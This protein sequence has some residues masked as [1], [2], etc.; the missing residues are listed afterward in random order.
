[1][2]LGLVAVQVLAKSPY[3]TV[4]GNYRSEVEKKVY[5]FEVV[6]GDMIEYA[7]TL[8]GENGS[9]AFTLVPGK[10]NFYYL[11]TRENYYRVYL[12]G[13]Q[14]L[15]VDVDT[16]KGA[17]SL[18]GKNSKENVIVNEWQNMIREV[19]TM[20]MKISGVRFIYT[21]F[22]PVLN[23]T[24]TEYERFLTR[25]NTK[26]EAFNEEMKYLADSD[27]RYYSLVFLSSGRMKHPEKGDITD[28]HKKILAEQL[29]TSRMLTLPYAWDFVEKVSSVTRNHLK[30]NEE[31]LEFILKRMDD[32]KMKSSFVLKHLTRMRTPDMYRRFM[33]EYGK[34]LV[35]AEDRNVAISKGSK[36][37]SLQP[38]SD[39]IDFSYPDIEGKTHSLSDYKGNVIVVDIW[40]TWCGPCVKEIP[41]FKKLEEE[42]KGQDVVFMGISVDQYKSKWE[43]FVKK[44]NLTAVQLLGTP[45]I[46]D[47]Y[48][49]KGIPRFMLF[50]KNGKIVTT[51]APRPSSPEL[52][53][54]IEKALHN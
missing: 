5:L 41:F 43:A 6:N 19:E 49:I 24:V 46:R 40:A 11:G 12:Q 51:D 33:E 17:I 37:N 52:K 21:D 26:N 42:F 53:S 32:P 35:V 47:N 7:S 54:M 28:F 31:H 22:Y 34:Y 39:A 23:K 50:D 25:I 30:N 38:G 14:E 4:M 9:F 1:M 27:I 16:E 15:R 8:L 18:V 2:I 13:G 45:E 3:A 36:Y 29:I 10:S 20:A 48:Q 44:E